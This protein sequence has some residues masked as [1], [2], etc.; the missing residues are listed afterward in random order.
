M[1]VVVVVCGVR[2]GGCE[3]G[4]DVMAAIPG[5][6]DH[7]HTRKTHTHALAPG[8][9][10]RCTWNGMTA[11]MWAGGGRAWVHVMPP[12]MDCINVTAE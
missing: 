10:L 1:V 9:A 3:E 5:G 11:T 6:S 7:G 12:S 8:H 2:G 4:Q